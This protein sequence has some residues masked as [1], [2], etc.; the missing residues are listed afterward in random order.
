MQAKFFWSC[1]QHNEVEQ[2]WPRPYKSEEP[3]VQVFSGLPPREQRNESLDSF[4]ASLD[5]CNGVPKAFHLLCAD[6]NLRFY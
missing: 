1:P 6:L 5:E 4:F 3:S 2:A